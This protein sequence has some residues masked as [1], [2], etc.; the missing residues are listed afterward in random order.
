MRRALPVAISALI[1][2]GVLFAGGPATPVASAADPAPST[3]TSVSPVRVLDT[4]FGTGTGTTTPVPSGGTITLDLSTKVP[5][6]TT[7][8][9]LNVTG[10]APT[11]STFVSVYPTGTTRPI[12]SNLNLVPGDTRPNQVTVP[13]GTNRSV[14]LFN[15]AGNTHL[16]ADLAGYYSPGSGARF[17]ALSPFRLVDTRSTGGPLGSGG[18]RVLDL[19][20][21]IPTSATAVTFN[22]TGTDATAST[23][24]TAFPTG[25]QVPNASNLNLPAG[26]T[27]ANLVTV[28]VGADRKVTLYNNAGSVNLI[29]DL[30]GFYTPEYG[31]V[32]VPVPLTRLLDTR[33]GTGTNGSTLPVVGGQ[34]LSVDLG[35]A[36]QLTA[37]GAVLN[38][39]GVDATASTFV[40]AFPQFENL[41]AVGSTINLSAGQTAPNAAV[42]A[43]SRVRGID[44]YNNAGR[45]HLIADLVGVFAVS[46]KACTSGCVYA[47]GDNFSRKLGT[48]E[49]VMD[50]P[51]PT[52]IPGLSGV[53]AVDGG[54]YRNGYALKDDGSVVAWGGNDDGQLGNGWTSDNTG[55]ASAIP[56]P[57]TGLRN[58]TAIAAG[59]ATAFALRD[60]GT[61][62]AWGAG[63]QGVLGN[64][65][66][67]DSSVPVQVSGLTNVVAIANSGATGYAVRDDGT[68]W[69]WGSNASG[70]L[71]RPSSDLGFSTTPLQV[72]GL[73]DITQVAAGGATGYA[74]TKGGDVLTWGNNTEGELG[75]GSTV[76]ESATPTRAANIKDVTAIAAGRYN[77]YAVQRDG[78]AWAWGAGS[79][80]AL[81]TGLDCADVEWPCAVGTPQQVSKLSDAKAITSFEYGGLVLRADGTVVGWGFNGS[82]TLANDE[83]YTALEPIQAGISGVS[84]LGAGE[85]SAY[86]VVPI[87]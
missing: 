76:A 39:T 43:L 23:F 32:F 19:V 65:A 74:L 15:N 49:T 69:A 24:V 7:A 46:E 60:D 31:S 16:V 53:K 58:I 34:I 83:Q 57:V 84:V 81:G 79:D 22:L 37:T 29:A 85:Y 40:T 68:V 35:K 56:V 33:V 14:N 13:L 2:A 11:A 80:G 28:A 50:S 66:S 87:P 27:R 62:W 38:I 3:Y 1:T 55:G 82:H 45:V 61:V 10:V 6:T 72:T 70:A 42:V 25:T 8:V 36:A 18:T 73:S 59:G 77:G 75:D 30:T 47:W 86:A 9:V 51:E 63:A 17:T 78:T 21:R 4:R 26:D 64:R 41:P 67:A 52:P 5:T 54:G 71:G 48:G 12:T 20:N 44:L